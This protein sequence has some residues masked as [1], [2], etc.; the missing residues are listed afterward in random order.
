M[1]NANNTPPAVLID[2]K[3]RYNAPARQRSS[4]P[5]VDQREMRVVVEGSGGSLQIAEH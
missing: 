4:W 1:Y 5:T 2:L 3:M